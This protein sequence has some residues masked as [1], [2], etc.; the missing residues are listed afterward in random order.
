[1]SRVARQCA[2]GLIPWLRPPQEWPLLMGIVNCTPDS[3]FSGG[4]TM[5]SSAA[6]EHALQLV[7]DGADII[8]VGGESTRP[9]AF[10]VEANEQLNRV[11]PVIEG[12]RRRSPVAISVDTTRAA[13][14]DAALLAG[15]DIVND[16]SGGLEDAALLGAVA[17]HAAGV[18]LMH[19]LRTPEQDQ[20]SN[21]YET[22]PTYGDVVAEVV[23]HLGQCVGAAIKAGV[24][25]E[26]I[27][28]DPGFGFGKSVE[29][30]REMLQRLCEF[31][32]TGNA[33]VVGLSRKSFLASNTG[34]QDPADRLPATLASGLVAMQASAAILRVH[35]VSEHAQVRAKFR[36]NRG[37]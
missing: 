19:R 23:A 10:T 26:R 13:V 2:Q 1:M 27:A 35:D 29:Q 9:G 22:P 33:V 14:A 18:I 5:D 16:V 36:A 31:T 11:M 21:Q 32:A 28:V 3:F 30:N 25:P 15:A 12:I 4:R 37:C 34:P 8:D 20:Y 17:R 7:A 24:A 6:I